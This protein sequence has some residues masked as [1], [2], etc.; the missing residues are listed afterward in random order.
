MSEPTILAIDLGTSG[1]KVALVSP[2]GV[3]LA[4]ASEPVQLTVLPHGGVEQNPDDWWRAIC[5]ATRRLL[6]QQS[7][8]ADVRGIC[9][10]AQWAGTIAIDEKGI[11]L[12]RALIWMDDRGAP[13]IRQ[14]IGGFPSV[15][16]YGAAKLWTWVRRTGGIPSPSGKDPVAHI[17]FLQHER[18]DI[19]ARTYKFLEP[20][21][22][23]NF[24]LT[25]RAL[26]TMESITL[27]WV[28]DNRDIHNIHYDP[29]LLRLAGLDPGKLPELCRAT[30]VLGPLTAAAAADLGLPQEV[31]VVGG[32]PDI[33]SAAIG[34]G[35]VADYAAHCY[36]GTSAWLGCHV[37]FKK[38][39]L[40]RNMAS[41]PS[42]LPGRYL[43]INEQETAGGCLTML[44]D[45]ILFPDDPLSGAPACADERGLLPPLPCAALPAPADF[46]AR[47]EATAAAAPAGS[48]RLIFTPWL[49]GER[50]PADDRTLRGGWHNASLLTTRS[51]LVRAV[52]EG[53]A[54]NMRW[55]LQ[56][57]ERFI[58]RRL[59]AIRIVGG[60]AR[61]VFWCQIFADVLC[62]P[63]LQ[64][65]E[66]IYANVRGAGFLGAL[67]LGLVSMDMLARE[68]PIAQVYEPDAAHQALY[69]DL[70]SAFMS[71]YHQNRSIYAV[72]NRTAS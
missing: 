13:H 46:F 71:I 60:G 3:V 10:T 5:T 26:A 32:T 24:R 34:S 67:G 12:T 29:D 57:V 66:P 59:D 55:L 61:S 39:D 27:H 70:F 14:R 49:H 15:Q 38:T 20:K 45:R 41:L 36:V 43:L 25:G 19:Y 47:L 17:L 42:A 65:A 4:G 63:I 35:A 54:Y 33:H 62:R 68:T 2:H 50:S 30:D 44:R 40:L 28:T 31:V 6:V 56:A 1:P 18:P 21:D 69:D 64:V 9:V 37:P 7:A 53:V 58:G 52:Y 8:A 23:I 22:Y 51:D 16:G 48:H 72:L 11:P